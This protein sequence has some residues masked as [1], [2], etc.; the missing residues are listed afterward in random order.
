MAKQQVLEL[1]TELSKANEAVQVAQAVVDTI[2]QKFYDLG[3]QETK[4][5]LT[6]ELAGVCREYCL[7]VW[8]GTLNVA[9]APT[10]SK[11]RKAENL[12]YLE[13]LR[14]DLKA[15]PEEATFTP[16][17]VEIGRAHV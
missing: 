10:N 2:G 15:A 13:D 8:I 5:Q 12:F 1:K 16:T 3:V 7:E 14:D 17:M 6:E 9:G 4:A 11:W